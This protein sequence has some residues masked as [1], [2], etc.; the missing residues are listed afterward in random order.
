MQDGWHSL[1][2]VIAGLDPAIHLFC[3][4]LLRSGMDPR[5][6]PAGDAR[7]WVSAEPLRTEPHLVR[8]YGRRRCLVGPARMAS[9]ILLQ[10]AGVI[11][12]EQRADEP[13]VEVRRAEQPVGDRERQVHVGL[14]HQ[15]PVVM[16]GMMA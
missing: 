10:V 8:T 7:E 12:V 1:S 14:H 11:A 4:T 9:Q 16:R 3:K 15:P 2:S 13:A 5:V 6:E